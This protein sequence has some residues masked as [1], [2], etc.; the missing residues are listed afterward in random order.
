MEKRAGFVRFKVTDSTGFFFHFKT[1]IW[2]MGVISFLIIEL[3]ICLGIIPIRYVAGVMNDGKFSASLI[4]ELTQIVIMDEWTP[5]SLSC[6]DAKR[7][8][9]G[10]TNILFFF[11]SFSVYIPYQVPAKILR[12]GRPRNFPKLGIREIKS[13]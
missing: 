13:Y 2:G 11:C 9:Q 4:N 5:D 1:K 12:I 3:F 7:V 6:E 8:L 10:I